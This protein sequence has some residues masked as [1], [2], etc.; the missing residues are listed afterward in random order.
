MNFQARFSPARA[1]NG[2]VPL[3]GVAQTSVQPRAC[4][5]RFRGDTDTGSS[6]GSAPRVRGTV[7][8][9]SFQSQQHR[10]SPARAGNGAP[11]YRLALP[12]AVQPR[13][14]GERE[15]QAVASTRV[16]GSAPRVRGTVPCNA[17]MR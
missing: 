2:A 10:F 9:G 5:E 8:R 16:D 12:Q 3:S 17:R 1:G 6:V 4:G 15:R 7:E 14:C 11:A 13:A